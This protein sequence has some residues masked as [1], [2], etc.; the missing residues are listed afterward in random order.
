M[1][2]SL[3]LEGKRGIVLG[4]ANRHSI[5]YGIAE[6]LSEQG[7]ELCITYLNEKSKPFVA[8]LA[9]KLTTKLFLPCDV[10]KPDE[11]E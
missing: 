4:I 11:L 3:S 6:V 9:E 8:S 2:T 10:S 5:A 1:S 7:A